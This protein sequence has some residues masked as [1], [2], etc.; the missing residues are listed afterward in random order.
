MKLNEKNKSKIFGNKI[1]ISEDEDNIWFN[2]L[3]DQNN[4]SKNERNLFTSPI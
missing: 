4:F 3:M 2:Y 1:L